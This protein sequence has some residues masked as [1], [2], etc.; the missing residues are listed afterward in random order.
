MESCCQGIN[1]EMHALRSHRDVPDGW[2][3]R[4]LLE[5]RRNSWQVR[6][7]WSRSLAT[8]DQNGGACLEEARV[9]S[10]SW[11]NENQTAATQRIWEEVHQQNSSK[12]L[13]TLGC[14]RSLRSEPMGKESTDHIPED[15][16]LPRRILS[17]LFLYLSLRKGQVAFWV[18]Y[19]VTYCWCLLR[20]ET[21]VLE[22]P[23]YGDGR[24]QRRLWLAESGSEPPI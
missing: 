18:R 11:K 16:I 14:R 24:V 4:L 1:I 9:Y 7:K 19:N 3:S 5:L 22:F 13:T 21:N 23:L 15:G 6:W 2:H 8:N 17:I 12:I 10:P 20:D